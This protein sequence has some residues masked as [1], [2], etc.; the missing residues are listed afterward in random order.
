M[1]K[2]LFVLAIVALSLGTVMPAF[3]QDS[4]TTSAEVSAA[5]NGNPVVLAAWFTAPG[6]VDNEPATPGLQ[7]VPNPGSSGALG[8]TQICV[9][10]VLWDPYGVSNLTGA[11]T[12]IYEPTSPCGT[13]MDFKVQIHMTKY[14]DCG[15]GSAAVSALR[16]AIDGGLVYFNPAEA[17]ASGVV[18]GI[19]TVEDVYTQLHN[20]G[21]AVYTA[22]FTYDNHQYPGCYTAEIIPTSATG[23]Q[24]FL[25]V[26]CGYLWI[27]E[28]FAFA[29]DFSA[30]DWGAI[31]RG[32]EDWVMGNT[33]WGDGVPTVHNQGNVAVYV[34]LL[35]TRMYQD[36]GI[37]PKYIDW[38]DARFMDYDYDPIYA[39][40]A[41]SLTSG[42]NWVPSA[43]DSAWYR[44][45]Q[46]VLV[47]CIPTKI[48]FSLHP[49]V[50]LLAGSY[51]GLMFLRAVDADPDDCLII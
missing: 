38:F 45:T 5:N 39:T 24:G 19:G 26:P 4:A 42:P 34:E 32:V 8:T 36:S 1:K 27:E 12:D 22:C 44:L 25:A 48:D 33:T 37:N 29:K 31:A 14:D 18:P 30:L 23:G 3:A 6:K 2:F 10:A 46:N 28:I 20:C 7:V 41:Y 40:S 47:P 51:S 9:W 15:A 17:G 49:P 16:A 43:G 35:F 11:P 50:D 13:D 21:L